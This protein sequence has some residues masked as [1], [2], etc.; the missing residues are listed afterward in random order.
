MLGVAKSLKGA[1]FIFYFNYLFW[2]VNWLSESLLPSYSVIDLH[3][4]RCS[5][6]SSANV[7]TKVG[8]SSTNVGY[9]CRRLEHEFRIFP[10]FYKNKTSFGKTTAICQLM[11]G[12]SWNYGRFRFKVG[13]VQKSNKTFTFGYLDRWRHSHCRFGHAFTMLRPFPISFS[14]LSP[15]SNVLNVL[16]SFP[17]LITQL[18]IMR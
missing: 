4:K 6:G 11:V 10:L 17:R 14:F 18:L 12:M 9:K 8:C 2:K 16:G 3:K 1:F 13:A 15:L 5:V 7:G